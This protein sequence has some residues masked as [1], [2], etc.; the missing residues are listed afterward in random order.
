MDTASSLSPPT[1]FVSEARSWMV[2][3]T[4]SFSWA[5]ALAPRRSEA[6]AARMT[7]RFMWS[8][9]KRVRA[10]GAD[11]ELQLHEQLGDRL[12]EVSILRAAEL[13][14]DLADP[15]GPETPV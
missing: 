12:V 13:A 2:V 11:G 1:S 4:L 5:N 9:L 6:R 8:P 10:V 3:T 15:G 7:M 14:A